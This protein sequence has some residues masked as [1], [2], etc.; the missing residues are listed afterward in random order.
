VE[1][2]PDPLVTITVNAAREIADAGVVGAS[3][4]VSNSVGLGVDY[5]FRRNVVIG[6]GVAYDRDEYDGIARDD[7]RFNALAKV[8]YAVNRTAAVFVQYDF[9]NQESSGVSAGRDYEINRVLV[10]LRLRR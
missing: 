6:L 7:D 1:Y 10:G 2:F 4:Y 3:S 8:D 9:Q 5:E